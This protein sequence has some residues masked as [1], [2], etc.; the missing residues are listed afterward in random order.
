MMIAVANNL[1]PGWRKK[2]EKKWLAGDG[3]GCAG[4]TFWAKCSAESR[5]VAHLGNARAPFCCPQA[6][7]A[8]LALSDPLCGDALSKART[9][10][11]GRRGFAP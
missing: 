5:P 9:L 3:K 6:Q 8:E 7:I 2:K 4:S 11:G 1:P 10:F